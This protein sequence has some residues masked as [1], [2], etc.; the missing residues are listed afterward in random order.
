MVKNEWQKQPRGKGKKSYLFIPKWTPKTIE[1]IIGELKK[2]SDIFY[3]QSKLSEKYGVGMATT[4][5][6]IGI[7]RRVMSDVD[8]GLSLNQSLK[9]DRLRRNIMRRKKSD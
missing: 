4:Y 1:W 8:S 3:I 2:N 9:R 6:W 5:G 7:A